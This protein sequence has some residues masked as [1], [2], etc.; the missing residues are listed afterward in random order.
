MAQYY[1]IL[2]DA[3]NTLL[4]FDAAENKALAET[5]D[6]YGLDADA[7]TMEL[8][9]QINSKLWKQLEKGEIRREKIMS[10]RFT[11]LLATLQ[12]RGNGTEMNRDYLNLLAQHPDT[13][14]G[15]MDVLDELAEVATLAIVS[16][17]VE[18]V[19]KQRVKDSGIENYMEEVFVS[20]AVG[21]DKPN[22]KFFDQALRVLGVEDRSHVLVVGDS[23]SGDIQGGINAG[24]DTCWYNPNKLENESNV[25][26][27]YEIQSLD[28]LYQIVM[29]DYELEN[30]GNK[31]RKHK[32]ED[33][34]SQ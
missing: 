13:I 7:E 11:R 27:T 18:H 32:S 22:R 19:Q 10:E 17:G 28:Q 5:L 24:L 26:P 34:V 8:Y 21:C 4:D 14:P 30:L 29:E 3:D 1:C 15:A 20:E 25:Q 33:L 2:F 12:A 6:A 31:N 23:L 9:R 16:N